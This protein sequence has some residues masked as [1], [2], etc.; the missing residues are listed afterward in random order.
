MVADELGW[1]ILPVNVAC[2]EQFPMHLRQVPC[3]SLALPL[4]SVRM[5]WRQGW[6]PTDSS[7]WV[8]QRFAELLRAGLG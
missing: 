1:A 5:I 8:E 2:D 6:P 3:P 7:R 4:L